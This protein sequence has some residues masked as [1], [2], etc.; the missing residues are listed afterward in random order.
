MYVEKYRDLYEHQ[1]NTLY[2]YECVWIFIWFYM[3]SD[4]D[5]SNNMGKI[6]HKISKI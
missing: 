4:I 5:T 3:N 1:Q 6:D 2:L